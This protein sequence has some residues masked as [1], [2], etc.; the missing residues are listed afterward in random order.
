LRFGANDFDLWT[1]FSAAYYRPVDALL[2]SVAATEFSRGLM[3]F[4]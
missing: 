3:V 1:R 2:R 4:E